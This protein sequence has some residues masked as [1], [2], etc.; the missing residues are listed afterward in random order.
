MPPVHRGTG[1]A[2]RRIAAVRTGGPRIP[3]AAG[4]HT[5]DSAGIDSFTGFVNLSDTCMFT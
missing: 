3:L 2:G 4:R 1:A 5:T